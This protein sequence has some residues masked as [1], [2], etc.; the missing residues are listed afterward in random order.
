MSSGSPL[1]KA[2]NTPDP[3]PFARARIVSGCGRSKV[4]VGDG[5]AGNAG[6]PGIV[7]NF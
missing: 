5:G 6:D 7:S 1:P 2:A 3:V 4:M